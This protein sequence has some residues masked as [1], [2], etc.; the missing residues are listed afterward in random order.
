[1]T[2]LEY[3]VFILKE[4]IRMGDMSPNEIERFLDPILSYGI[5]IGTNAEKLQRCEERLNDTDECKELRR[6][7]ARDNRRRLRE[8]R[9]AS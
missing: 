7:E 8:A 9:E 5:E 6:W 2:C 3:F 1:M 4:R